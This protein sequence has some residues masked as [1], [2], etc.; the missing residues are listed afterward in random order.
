MPWR[1]TPD[2]RERDRRSVYVFVKRNLRYPLFALFDAPDRNETCSRR[3][4]TTTA[5][6]ALTLLNDA[7]VLGFA[8]DF[9]ARVTKEVGTEPS[10]V[11]KRAFL[12]ALGRTPKDDERATMLEFLKDH[13]GTSAEAATDLCHTLM[14]L[15]EFLYVD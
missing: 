7:I 3:F 8:K 9:G 10:K 5:P 13:K 14:N 4:N 12:L 6:Q 2:A 15:N 11:V 1:V